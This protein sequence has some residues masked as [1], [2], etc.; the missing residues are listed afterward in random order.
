MPASIRRRRRDHRSRS[1]ASRPPRMSPSR[2]ALSRQRYGFAVSAFRP[3]GLDAAYW[4]WQRP[5]VAGGWSLASISPKTGQRGAARHS[6]LRTDRAARLCRPARRAI[7]GWPSSMATPSGRLFY[8][9][10]PVAVAR[11]W[12]ISQLT[13]PHDDLRKR[14][15]LSPAAP[16]PTS[17]DPGATV[18][19]CLSVGVNQIISRARRLPQRRS[20]RQAQLNAGTNCGSC[21]AE[22]RGIIDGCL[23]AAA[24]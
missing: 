17:L 7:S 20:R 9:R 21:R 12:A 19:S 23:A 11:N 5:R 1:P 13:A 22:I 2:H 8:A 6:P 15:A 14:F 3:D 24:E 18:C 16:V 10:R 4:A